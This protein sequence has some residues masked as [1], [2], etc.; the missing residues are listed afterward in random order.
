MQSDWKEEFVALL[1]ADWKK[2]KKVGENVIN[3][4]FLKIQEML[5]RLVG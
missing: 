1:Q 5:Q 2:M 4:E 3:D